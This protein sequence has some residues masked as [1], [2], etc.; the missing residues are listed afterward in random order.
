[1]KKPW[2][3]ILLTIILCSFGSEQTLNII[4]GHGVGILELN[5]TTK[6]QVENYLG[7]GKQIK[8][9]ISFCSKGQG[10]LKKFVYS[11]I[12]LELQYSNLNP[13]K[14]DTLIFIKITESSKLKTKEGIGIGSSRRE[15]ESFLGK[16]KTSKFDVLKSGELNHYVKYEDLAIKFVFESQFQPSLDTLD[17]KVNRIEMY[18]YYK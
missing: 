11:E 2:I 10:T 8:E 5:I 13:K 15:V 4:P 6:K 14:N 12:G 16:T 7:K 1:M 3:F 9:F 18:K 17:Y